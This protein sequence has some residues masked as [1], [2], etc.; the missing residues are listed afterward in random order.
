MHSE[1]GSFNFETAVEGSRAADLAAASI[2]AAE[3]NEVAEFAAFPPFT[4]YIPDLPP[5]AQNEMVMYLTN[6]GGTR[7]QV[8]QRDDDILTPQQVKDNWKEVEEAM[9]KELKTWAK[10]KCFSRKKRVEARNI[11]DTRWVLKFKWELPT[12]SV[13][14][15]SG[16]SRAADARRT[17]RARLTV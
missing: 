13:G 1:K 9:G 5:L 14:T 3:V 2:P 7:R 15:T 11:I 16:G 8:V 6:E 4:K 17:I 12:S 10:Y